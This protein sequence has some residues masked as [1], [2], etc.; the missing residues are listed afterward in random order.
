MDGGLGQERTIE[1]SAAE[2]GETCR[3][4]LHFQGQAP[5]RRP[6]GRVRAQQLAEVTG[7][8]PQRCERKGVWADLASMHVMESECGRAG[9]R[10][11][12][13]DAPKLRLVHSSTPCWR[14]SYVPAGQFTHAC[15][16]KSG[17]DVHCTCSVVNEG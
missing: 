16:C 7:A 10:K 17:A 9:E 1:A 4:C 3:V 2:E 5:C 11:G 15:V 13:H 12:R 8:P 14:R 6:G